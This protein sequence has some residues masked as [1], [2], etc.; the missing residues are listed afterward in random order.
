[1]FRGKID[2]FEIK[3]LNDWVV[4]GEG[5][6]SKKKTGKGNSKNTYQYL[7]FCLKEIYLEKDLLLTESF[8]N[9][10]ANL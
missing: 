1:M 10:P 2:N 8:R 5:G 3:E 4:R 7:E 6:G 9:V